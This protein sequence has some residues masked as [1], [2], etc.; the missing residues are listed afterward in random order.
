MV[1]NEDWRFPQDVRAI[2][3][4]AGWWP[5]RDVSTWVRRWLASV[6]A[7]NPGAQ[8]RLLLF[9]AARDALAEFGGLRFT[10]LKRS[11]YAGGGFRVETWPAAGRV[12]VELYVEFGADLGVPVFPLAWYEDGSSDVV[13]A[14]DGRVFLLHPAAEF[15]VAEGV[16]EAITALVRG[17][18]LREVDD[19]GRVIG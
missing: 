13:V 11:G 1:G 10:Q 17:A 7:E 18:R 12:V 5:G 4:E 14:A 19:H 3:A 6:Y 2:L 8:Q 16:D 15:L 9:P